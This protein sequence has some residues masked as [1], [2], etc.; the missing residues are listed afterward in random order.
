MAQ[1]P[2]VGPS[3]NLR[4]RKA[5]VQRSIN[6]FPSIVESGSG[7]APAILQSIPGLVLFADTGS[8]IRAMKTA[9]DGRLYVV[10]GNTLNELDSLG[11]ITN[12]GTL[13]TVTGAADIALNLKELIVVDGPN[14]YVCNFTSNIFAQI[15]AA[16]FNGSV[17]VSVLNG[18]AI[19][20]KPNSQQFSLSGIDD[21]NLIDTL[22]FAS[23]ES[24]P[25]NIVTHIVDHGQV[26]FFGENGIEIW[27]DT[28]GLDFPL[29]RNEGAK[30]ETGVSAAF[31]VQKLDNTV[32]WLGNDE[33]GGGILWKLSGFTP[34]RVSTQAI[35]EMLQSV[36]DLS[37]AVAYTY[38]Q[39]GHSFYCL[40][41]PGLDTTLCYDVAS[42][43]WHERAELIGGAYAQHRGQ[44]HAYAF[45]KHLVGT[46]S[47]KIY[48][49]DPEANTNAGNILVRD[50]ISPHQALPNYQK[51]SYGSLQIDCV[52]GRGIPSGAAPS[53]MMRYSNDGGIAYGNWRTVS[54]GAIGARNSRCIYRRLGEGYDRVWHVR[55]TDDTQFAI[56]GANVE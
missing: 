5:D 10:S 14:G 49:Y 7:K 43:S 22:D 33:R 34:V 30:I 47:G 42:G 3:Y 28:G 1:I 52:V 40:N 44:F 37:Q 4:V 29:T 19:Y 27:D 50:R 6:L 54:M 31:S 38:Q 18:R 16:A 25:D 36:G 32:F 9:K 45:G 24:S 46:S 20:V 55:M 53:L 41:V 39:D 15:N 23:A 48:E 12:R 35:E 51:I 8:E 2:I 26:F 17:R 21:A 56:V 11:A 13:A